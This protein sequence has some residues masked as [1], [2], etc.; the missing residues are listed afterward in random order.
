[1]KDNPCVRFSHIDPFDNVPVYV[2][3]KKYKTDKEAMEAAKKNNQKCLDRLLHKFVAYKCPKCGFWHIG[4]SNHL[5]T[6]K[7]KRTNKRLI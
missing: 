2:N 5:I 1:M 4:R 3:K 6:E 7:Q